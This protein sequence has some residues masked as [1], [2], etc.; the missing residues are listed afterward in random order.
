MI[1][2]TLGVAT[3]CILLALPGG[4]TIIGDF[5]SLD[6]LITRADAIAVIRIDSHIGEKDRLHI[7]IASTPHTCY[8]Y[9][10]LKGDIPVGKAV[11]MRL[12]DTSFAFR[13]AFRLSSTHLVFLRKHSKDDKGIEYDSLLWQGANLEVSPFGNEKALTGKPVKLRIQMLV[14][15][16]REYRLQEAKREDKLLNKVLA[17]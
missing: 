14:K 5:D 1:R 13:E 8:V 7:D 16:Y 10:T 15:T 4:A 6:A 17:P 12:A 9:Q 11:P 2:R 3:L